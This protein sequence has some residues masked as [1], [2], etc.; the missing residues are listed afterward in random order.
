MNNCFLKA[1]EIEIIIESLFVTFKLGDKK[2]RK[3][4]DHYHL[5]GAKNVR[6]TKSIKML[7]QKF[8]I[9]KIKFQT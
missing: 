3:Q 2:T 5:A 6:L 7:L 8:D 9:R 1:A 4:E